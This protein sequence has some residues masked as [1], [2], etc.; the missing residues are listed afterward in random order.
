MIGEVL[1]WGLK[2]Y[3]LAVE[4]WN[5]MVKVLRIKFKTPKSD[6][7]ENGEV[8]GHLALR[9][10]DTCIL[11]REGLIELLQYV[12]KVF[13]VKHLTIISGNCGF[14]RELEL[15][16]VDCKCAIY[17]NYDLV[18]DGDQFC[19]NLVDSDSENLFLLKLKEEYIKS[20]SD[21]IVEAIYN[22]TI[23]SF[24]SKTSAHVNNFLNY[25]F[26]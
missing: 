15:R 11:N 8:K 23:K 18:K 10:N 12:H 17:Y 16:S 22:N 5:L 14:E 20:S 9:L 3:F 24:T 26:C 6:V 2:W 13:R 4:H 21:E 19:I 7:L 25:I 1:V